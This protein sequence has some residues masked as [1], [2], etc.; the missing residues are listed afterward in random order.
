MGTT[1]THFSSRHDQWTA[2]SRKH[3]HCP[4]LEARKKVRTHARL[5]VNSVAWIF[6]KCQTDDKRCRIQPTILHACL[7]LNWHIHEAYSWRRNLAKTL[8]HVLHDIAPGHAVK[9][10]KN[11]LIARQ[12]STDPVVASTVHY[13]EIDALGGLLWQT[14]PNKVSR[15]NEAPQ[16]WKLLP[17]QIHAQ[18]KLPA[19]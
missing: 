7:L 4:V 3:R 1:M 5:D 2:R 9:Y 8:A 12:L 19:L 14:G 17:K 11:G 10:S 15:V 16:M 13:V 6:A 18:Q